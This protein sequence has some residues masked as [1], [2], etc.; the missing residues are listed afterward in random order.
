MAPTSDA[1]DLC[2]FSSTGLLA[3]WSS[4]ALVYALRKSSEVGVLVLGYESRGWG[5]YLS[6]RLLTLLRVGLATE[7]H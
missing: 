4:S 3:A 1:Y 7:L 5:R 2:S 6:T